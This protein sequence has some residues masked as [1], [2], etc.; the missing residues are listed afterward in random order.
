MAVVNLGAK[1]KVT[2]CYTMENSA[3]ATLA[4]PS[5]RNCWSS[6]SAENLNITEN[7]IITSLIVRNF[8]CF[9]I[10]TWIQRGFR[11]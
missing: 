3:G 8:T 1:L 5:L 2:P 4:G 6:L 11:S 9:A 7:N 10:H